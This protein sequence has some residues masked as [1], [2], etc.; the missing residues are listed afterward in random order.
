MNSEHDKMLNMRDKQKCRI[1][2][3]QSRLLFGICDAWEVL[4]EGQCAFK[5]TRDGDGLPYALKNT[6][7]LVTRNPFL[8]PGDL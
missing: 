3:P 2:V 5:V 8:H 6:E 7:V 1:L 4:K